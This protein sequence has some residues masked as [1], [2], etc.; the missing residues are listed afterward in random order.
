MDDDRKTSVWPWIV[1]L[2]IGLP[3]LYVASFGP[4]LWIAN[5]RFMPGALTPIA[6]AAFEPMFWARWESPD[7]IRTPVEWYARFWEPQ[8]MVP[9]IFREVRRATFNT[10]TLRDSSMDV[11]L[12]ASRPE[13]RPAD[14]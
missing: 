14:R 1:A 9:A 11:S 12:P 13:Q 3:V 8:R 6:E 2:L 5:H 7:A 4:F 10:G